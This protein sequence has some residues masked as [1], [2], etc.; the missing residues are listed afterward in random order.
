MLRAS[1]QS[2]AVL[3]DGVFL[4]KKNMRRQ[5]AVAAPSNKKRKLK[6]LLLCPRPC[7]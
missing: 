2:K 1:L 7:S 6:A 4:R 5:Q 3:T